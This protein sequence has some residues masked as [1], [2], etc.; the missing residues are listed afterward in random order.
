VAITSVRTV[1]SPSNCAR[2]TKGSLL[3]ASL[4]F[5]EEVSH[6]NPEEVHVD[7]F[8]RVQQEVEAVLSTGLPVTSIIAREL[9]RICIILDTK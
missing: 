4:E 3:R 6:C 9:S 8:P 5:S 1:S 2:T 7:C